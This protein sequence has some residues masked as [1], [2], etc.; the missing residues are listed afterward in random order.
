MVGFFTTIYRITKSILEHSLKHNF[1]GFVHFPTLPLQIA[2]FI[3]LRD[4]AEAAAAHLCPYCH[5]S[6]LSPSEETKWRSKK[7]KKTM[8][9][10]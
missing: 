5:F 7:V 3:N 8:N 10:H 1:D 9:S 6:L 2:N 4:R